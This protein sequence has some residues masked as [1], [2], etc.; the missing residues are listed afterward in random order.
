VPAVPS[1]RRSF[2]DS[3]Q[4]LEAA[5]DSGENAGANEASA[6]ASRLPR[7]CFQTA[8]LLNSSL[9]SLGGGHGVYRR[10]GISGV[11]LCD[12]HYTLPPLLFIALPP[13]LGALLRALLPGHLHPSSDKNIIG[14]NTP[15]KNRSG[16][17]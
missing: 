2:L 15:I 16:S 5:T 10:L 4:A 6:G 14:D 13:V 12:D 3:R 9:I 1:A 17:Q 11:E 7:G 8:A